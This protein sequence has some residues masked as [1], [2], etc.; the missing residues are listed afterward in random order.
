MNNP[1]ESG[2]G[3]REQIGRLIQTHW[4]WINATLTILASF[5]IVILTIATFQIEASVKRPNLSVQ[6]PDR[7]QNYK[8]YDH[9]YVIINTGSIVAKNINF[10]AKIFFNKQP[11][12]NNFRNFGDLQPGPPREFE[13]RLNHGA[14]DE[15]TFAYQS[16][17]GEVSIKYFGE[18]RIFRFWCTPFYETQ[19]RVS[20]DTI[21]KK[22]DFM[23]EHFPTERE[24]CE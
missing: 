13:V 11:I 14:I 24:D 6:T 8:K 20:F 7:L 10:K 21:T 2:P 18:K 9:R 3:F 12:Y 22:W 4:P 16:L 15:Q 5:M 1:P 19:F 23:K 17:V